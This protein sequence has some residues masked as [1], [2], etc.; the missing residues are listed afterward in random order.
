MNPFSW[1][2]SSVRVDLGADERVFLPTLVV[3]LGTVGR[4]GDDPAAD[5]LDPP[6]YRDDAAAEA[7]YQRLMGTELEAARA[8][9]RERFATTIQA[10]HLSRDDAESWLRILGDARLV[11]AARKGIVQDEDGWE[12]RVGDD[13]EL[14]MLAYL[15]FLQGSLVDALATGLEAGT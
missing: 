1:D 13:P 8:I 7:E 2:G 15:G 4:S 9:D 6:A 3:F 12:A 10:D 11:L 14:G 5:R